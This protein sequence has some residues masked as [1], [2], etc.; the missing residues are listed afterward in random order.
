MDFNG[1]MKFKQIVKRIEK[2]LAS[3]IEDLKKAEKSITSGVQLFSIYKRSL[4]VAFNFPVLINL[5]EEDADLAMKRL[6][7]KQYK[8]LDG[9]AHCIYYEKIR[10]G[11]AGADDLFFNPKTL[12]KEELPII[13]GSE[14]VNFD[15]GLGN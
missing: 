2:D 14:A 8:D 12:I 9:K 1:V 4:P 10:V 15:Y 7:I 6:K 13:R 5:T 3:P 11:E